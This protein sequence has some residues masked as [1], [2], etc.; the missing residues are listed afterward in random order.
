MNSLP[1]RED[2]SDSLN[3]VFQVSSDGNVD[4]EMTLVE[5]KT[6]VSNKIQECFSLLFRTTANDAPPLQQLFKLKHDDLGEMQ[7]FLVPIKKN[8]EGLFFEAVF[9]KLL[10]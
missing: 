1:T 7:L 2:F 9:N 5:V 8:E 6:I 10:A 4:F 3:T